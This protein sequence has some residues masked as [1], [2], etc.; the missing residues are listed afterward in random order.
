MTGTTRVARTRQTVELDLFRLYLDEIGRHRLLTAED[1]VRLAQAYEAA[2]RP[3]AGWPP[4]TPAAPSWRPWPSGA[5]GPGA[6]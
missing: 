5:S 2:W 4:A 6:R 3:G 1:E